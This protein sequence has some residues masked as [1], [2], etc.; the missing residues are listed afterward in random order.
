MLIVSDDKTEVYNTIEYLRNVYKDITVERGKTHNYLGMRF[1][2][3]KPGEVF[4]SMPKFTK[5]IAAENG[6]QGTADTPASADL[7]NI[8]E[9][10]PALNN[11]DRERFHRTV[12][13]CLHAVTRTR[14]DASLP[15]IFLTTRVLAPTEQDNNK[16]ERV[17]KY[18]NGTHELGIHLGLSQDG[19]LKLTCFVDANHGVHSNGKSHSG[20]MISH[21]RGAILEKSAKQKI[22]CRSSTESELVTLSDATSLTAYELQFMQSLVS[23]CTKLTKCRITHL[24]FV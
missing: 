13:Q 10:S 8:D 17:L 16:L 20:I 1:E 9:S 7:F 23:K 12:A 19:D 6:M 2:F 15:I 11:V 18:F 5:E 4:V 24:L 22:V 3:S 14:P 21:G